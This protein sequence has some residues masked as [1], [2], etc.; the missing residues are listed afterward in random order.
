MAGLAWPNGKRIAVLVSVLL[1][2]WSPGKSP[3]YFPRTTPLKPGA[4]DH[5]GMQWSHYGGR[6]GIWR[7]LRTLERTGVRATVFANALSAE[8]YPDAIRA[9]VRA[10]HGLAGHGHAQDQYL[11]DMTTEQ[12]Q[13][14]IRRSLD[15]L[16]AASGT[17]PDG[18][19]CSVYS[20]NEE[21]FALLVRAGVRWHADALDA[22]LPRLQRTEAGPIVALP[23][24]DFVDNRVLRASPRDFHD[25]YKDSFDYLYAAEPMGLLH[26]AVHSHF[27]GRPLVAAQLDKL[28]RYFTGFTDVWMP[29]HAELVDW[30]LAQKIDD[31]NA[32][33]RASA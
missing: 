27:G 32:A 9:V 8:L 14:V 33:R 16:E 11:C 4:I 13:G 30:F 10:G 15:V 3:S 20:W 17:R 29:R 5:A 2:N 23:W 24:C 25:V 22:A 21:T 1:E 18:W 6:E 19:V 7:I 26:L 31:P 28:L 12:Q